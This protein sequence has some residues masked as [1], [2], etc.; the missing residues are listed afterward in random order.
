MASKHSIRKLASIIDS[1]IDETST[2]G[3]FVIMRQKNSYVIRNILN[4]K[5]YMVVHSEVVADTVCDLM[6]RR[7]QLNTDKVKEY[8]RIANKHQVDLDFYL[9]AYKTTNEVWL[10]DRI[11][12]A[13]GRIDMVVQKLSHM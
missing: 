7:P 2:R 11:E 13:Q 4:Q 8:V 9:D 12:L 6:N 10:A 5:D 3:I 1:V